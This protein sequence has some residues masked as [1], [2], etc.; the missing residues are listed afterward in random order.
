MGEYITGAVTE[1][2]ES[3]EEHGGGI[4]ILSFTTNKNREL[5][6]KSGSLCSGR[7]L[8][9]LFS[10]L[11]KSRKQYRLRLPEGF[12]I[13]GRLPAPRHSFGF[14]VSWMFPKQ[15][16]IRRHLWFPDDFRKTVHTLLLTFHRI[17]KT[18]ENT[19]TSVDEQNCALPPSVIQNIIQR[20][21]L[22]EVR[23]PSEELKT[24][25]WKFIQETE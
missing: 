9:V 11:S 6:I 18:H 21:S 8:F 15:W 16:T 2:M 23:L 10:K 25:N 12:G 20:W 3:N 14:Y 5:I 7:C 1:L 17:A 19:Q 4:Y 13:I 22:S 24:A